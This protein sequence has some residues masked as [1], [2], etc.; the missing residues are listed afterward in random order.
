MPRACGA[1]FFEAAYS[2]AK[3]KASSHADTEVVPCTNHLE[4]EFFGGLFKACMNIACSK[5]I[6]F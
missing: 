2:T 5:D 6:G 4:A 3:R 1:L